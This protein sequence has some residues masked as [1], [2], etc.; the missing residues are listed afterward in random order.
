M[1]I[2]VDVSEVNV[3]QDIFSALASGVKT[4]SQYSGEVYGLYAVVGKVPANSPFLYGESYK[5][6]LYIPFPSAAGGAK[7]LSAGRLASDK[8]FN[9]PESGV[10]PTYVG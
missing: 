4:V 2:S 8:S 6:I 1:Q 9:N 5:S 10:P 7:P 3:D